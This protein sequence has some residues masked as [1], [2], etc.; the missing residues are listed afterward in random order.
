MQY[1]DQ[2]ERLLEQLEKVSGI[3]F[4]VEESSLSKEETVAKLREILHH[5][6]ALGDKYFFVLNYLQGG[7]SPEDL[8]VGLHRYHI[9]E[10]VPRMVYCIESRTAIGKDAVTVLKNFLPG[11]DNLLL[12]ADENRIVL[13]R[14]TAPDVK[15]EEVAEFAEQILA[16]LETEAFLSCRISYDKPCA[17]FGELPERYE[18]ALLAMEI[19][20]R[21]YGTE[22][23]F[24]F[25]K[26]DL[27][28]LLYNVPE[29]EAM[30]FMNRHIDPDVLETID[31]A[32][33]HTL[34][35]FF[36]NDLSVTET[37][38]QLFLHRNTLIYRL[39]KFSAST[40]LDVRRFSDAVSCC[41][42]L[43]LWEH[44]RTEE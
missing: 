32:M 42:A 16:V 24:A 7:L 13:V 4:A 38:K 18:N 15:P 28:R 2:V 17:V 1:E 37:A 25:E 3:R 41:L 27:G 10:N 8:T 26:L 43:M 33:L 14:Q 5:Y 20:K 35:V 39:D 12:E 11:T 34:H 44:F 22:R 6:N 31:E 21:F 19:G 40:G 30:A 23:I 36:E 9:D 29:D